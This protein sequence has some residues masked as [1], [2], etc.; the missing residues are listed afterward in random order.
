MSSD[1]REWT[2]G[3]IKGRAVED[4]FWVDILKQ[5]EDKT[6][7]E[8]AQ[9]CMFYADEAFARRFYSEHSQ[10]PNFELI[11]PQIA[12]KT[13]IAMKLVG[14]DAIEVWR[15][16]MGSYKF[17]EREPGTIRHKY[18]G[19]SNIPYEDSIVHGSVSPVAA[20]NEYGVCPLRDLPQKP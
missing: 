1:S 19:Y 4:G 15:K 20:N 3:L 14:D 17:G 16:L 6:Y 7:L 11:I 2:V 8:V 5:I 10:E 12:N 9:L 18:M 13:I